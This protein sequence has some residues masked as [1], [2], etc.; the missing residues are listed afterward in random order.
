MTAPAKRLVLLILALLISVSLVSACSGGTAAKPTEP[1]KESAS[2]KA[3]PKP[4]QAT[5]KPIGN[6]GTPKSEAPA[7]PKE[8][9]TVRIGMLGSASDA[10]VIIAMEKGYFEQEGLR[11]EVTPFDTAAKMIAPLGS[12]QLD[13]GGGALGAGLFNAV[14]R[15]VTVKVVADKGSF[16][17]KHGFSPLVLRKDLYDSGTIKSLKDLKGR[18]V[19]IT[20]LG[21]GPHYSLIKAYEQAGGN[22]KDIELVP[23]AHTDMIVALKQKAVDA[24]V[25][26]EPSAVLMERD[27]Y[28]VRWIPADKLV[29]NSQNAV[30]LYSGAWAAKDP[31]AAK[32]FMVAYIK[33]VR[34]YND[35]FEKNKGKP[36][37]IAMLIKHT[38]LK[39]ASVYDQMITPG[40]NPNGKV[41]KAD[42]AQQ[43]QWYMEK[44][45][46]K[47]PAPIDQLVDDQYVEYAV[48][49]LGEYK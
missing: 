30:V 38:T 2:P 37:V 17:P 36:E 48:K 31:D 32:G 29:P 45:L 35:A 20:A 27:G 23:M 21:A 39:D 18:K 25:V 33:G 40:L 3:S 1:A 28:A 5:P 10:G 22:E 34:D 19:A 12:G 44:G 41:N 24:G 47:T 11:M 7:A 15:D 4:E 9:K 46:V 43:Q 26:T 49:K 8:L 13:V 6:V 16:L 42:I 14:A